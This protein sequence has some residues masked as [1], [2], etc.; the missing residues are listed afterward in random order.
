MTG[1]NPDHW[2][3]LE[4]LDEEP[5]F[6][7]ASFSLTGRIEFAE[8][9]D[10]SPERKRRAKELLSRTL[11]Y[12]CDLLRRTPFTREGWIFS[13]E[14]NGF[15][16]QG[17]ELSIDLRA[18][19]HSMDKQKEVFYDSQLVHEW[20]HHFRDQEDLSMFAELIH[21]KEH[22]AWERIDQI[23]RLYDQ[24]LAPASRFTTPYV[25]GLEQVAR[26]LDSSP[27]QLAETIH[28][29]PLETLKDVFARYGE[30]VLRQEGLLP[31][32]DPSNT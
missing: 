1:Y 6:D 18:L 28:M 30:A 24:R 15:R 23:Q 31:K 11:A 29:T 17:S 5:I 27:S 16:A 20:M 3:P 19:D 13:I 4:T 10:Q 12:A 22:Q 9:A 8:P 2:G 21:L 26:L 32:E 14:K 7:G 25:R